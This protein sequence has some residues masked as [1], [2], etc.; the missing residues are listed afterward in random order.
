M[1]IQLTEAEARV[2]TLALAQYTIE[3]VRSL[4]GTPYTDTAAI[5]RV[6]NEI[7]ECGGILNKL[8]RV[9]APE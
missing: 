3:L 6:S 5:S 7:V 9:R 4:H 8:P 2:V 1:N